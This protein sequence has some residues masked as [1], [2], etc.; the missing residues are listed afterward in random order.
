MERESIY[1][2]L[3]I[4][5]LVDLTLGFRLDDFY[6]VLEPYTDFIHKEALELQGYEVSRIHLLINK[7][8]ADVVAYMS[9]SADSIRLSDSE[10]EQYN[11]ESVGFKAIPAI[12]IG[13][14]AVAKVYSEKYRGIGT[15]LIELVRGVAFSMRKSGVACRFITVDA[16]ILNNP[17]VLDFYFKSGF[18]LNEEYH[19][20]KNPSLRLDIESD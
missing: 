6:C 18:T 9:L 14:L 16:D 13:H 7:T 3:S 2:Y 17:S 11:M 12:K 4:I 1:D 5:Q 10:K 19:R 8:N 20:R 15:L